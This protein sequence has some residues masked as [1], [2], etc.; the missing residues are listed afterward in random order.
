MNINLTD[1]PERWFLIMMALSMLLASLCGARQYQ[2]FCAY[3]YTKRHGTGLFGIVARAT[4]WG[5]DLLDTNHCR[6]ASACF[7]RLRTGL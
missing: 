5:M 4:V 3:C 6:K 1:R 2:S 7:R